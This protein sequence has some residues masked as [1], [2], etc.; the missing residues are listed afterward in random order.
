MDESTVRETAQS[1]GDAVVAGDFATAGAAL[2][3]ESS[4]A[5]PAIMKA[6]PRPL[7]KAEV[8]A[9][10]PQGDGFVARI[11]YSGEGESVVIASTWAE[12]DGAAKIVS[13]EVL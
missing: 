13:L 3:P 11:R 7:T 1:H 12:V 4:A 2:T 10:E 5:A 6:L 9:V 8:D